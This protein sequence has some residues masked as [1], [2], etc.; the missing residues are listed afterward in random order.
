MVPLISFY[1]LQV[2]FV[3]FQINSFENLTK[4]IL[5]R[6]LR[7][8]NDKMYDLRGNMGLGCQP[9]FPTINIILIQ[10]KVHSLK[11]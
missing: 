7:S 11:Q 9:M 10:T 3:R 5:P 6:I 4:I 1:R 8:D 2:L